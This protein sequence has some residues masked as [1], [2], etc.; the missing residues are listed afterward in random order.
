MGSA[1]GS[2]TGPGTGTVTGRRPSAETAP[3]TVANLQSQNQAKMPETN[4]QYLHEDSS[5]FDYSSGH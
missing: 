2:G 3:Q 1:I 5:D 4:P